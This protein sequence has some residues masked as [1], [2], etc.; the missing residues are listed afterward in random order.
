MRANPLRDSWSAGRVACG[1]WLAIPSS[2]TAEIVA[3]AD[4]DYLCVDMQ[5]GLIDYSDSVH[6]LQ[7]LTLGEVTPTV[8]VPENS[9]SHISKALDAG[10]MAIIVPMV[11]SRQECQAAVDSCFYSPKGARSYG[12]TRAA[13]VEG[14]DYYEIANDVIACIPMVE[15]ADAINDLDGIL[16]IDGVDAIYVGPADLAISMGMAPGGAQPEFLAALDAIVAACQQHNVVP[17]IHATPSTA[18]DRID[19]EFRMV[20]VVADLP[21]F[22]AGI[23]ASIALARGENAS[24]H[25]SLY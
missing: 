18:S 5:H 4:L 17:G 23:T 7:A 11:N 15:T 16:S 3:A 22:S 24:A 9:P 19:R 1:G 2:V 20:T 21:V 13:S 14:S 12:P 8:R 6:M 25:D 10:A